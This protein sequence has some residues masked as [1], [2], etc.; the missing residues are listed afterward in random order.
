MVLREADAFTVIRKRIEENIEWA[1]N[2]V[3]SG[4]CKDYAGYMALVGRIEGMSD[5][6]G[7]VDELERKFLED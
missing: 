4:N 7:M 3:S 2:Y 5:V 1:R 6:L